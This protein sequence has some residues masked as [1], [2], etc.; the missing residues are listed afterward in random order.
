[1]DVDLLHEAPFTDHGPEDLFSGS[2]VDAPA[3]APTASRATA[4]PGGGV[5]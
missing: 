4:R 5:A 3:E 1:M 2:D